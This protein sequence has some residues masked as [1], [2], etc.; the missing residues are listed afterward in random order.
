MPRL[1]PTMETGKIVKWHVK[2]GEKVSVGTLI[3]DIET[4]KAV[5]ELE[6]DS[7]G[8]IIKINYQ[9]SSEGIPV[10]EIIGT[11]LFDGETKQDIDSHKENDHE[12]AFIES[13]KTQKKAQP[14]EIQTNNINTTKNI[15][16]T[17]IN[18]NT[19]QEV[20]IRETKASP[21]ARKIAQKENIDLRKIKGTGPMGRIVKQDV[22]KYT[23]EV[24]VDECTT[25][26][27]PSSGMRKVIAQRLIE[28]KT[29]IP[30]FY[31]EEDCMI[32]NLISIKNEMKEKGVT[33]NDIIIKAVASSITQIPEINVSWDNEHIIKYCT[34]DI[35][36][37]VAINDGLITPILRNAETKTLLQ[38]SQETKSLIHKA[39][40][41]LLKPE[42]YQGGNFTISNLG[43]F[44]VK[45]FFA[46]INPPQSAILSV[47]AAKPTPVVDTRGDIKVSNVMSI[48][49]SLDHRVIDGSIGAKFIQTLKKCLENPIWMCM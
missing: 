18:N 8:T 35:S 48:S 4:D 2:I 10:D 42:E 14:D 45:K 6:S 44:G 38:I 30:H 34:A 24:K 25:T 16:Q 26:K 11:I 37:A 19:I 47:G 41:S 9:E 22:M 27:I 17:N 3:A 5:M 21:V 28:S 49:L 31:M 1:S 29:T 20:N 32:D 7:V 12:N 46:I 23:K 40:N 13:E 43:M 33:L 15:E 39:K 36:V